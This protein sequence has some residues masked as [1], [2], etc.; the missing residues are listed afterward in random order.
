[1]SVDVFTPT[2]DQHEPSRA[3]GEEE[4]ALWATYQQAGSKAAGRQKPRHLVADEAGGSS[5]ENAHQ[6]SES[7]LRKSTAP[8]ATHRS[9][10]VEATGTEATAHQGS[11]ESWTMPVLRIA[12]VSPRGRGF[13]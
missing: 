10:D 7:G 6:N 9:G 12:G 4:A 13:H 3:P 1:M 11:G 2:G 5:H 8:L